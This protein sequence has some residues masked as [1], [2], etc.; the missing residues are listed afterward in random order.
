MKKI[1]IILLIPM[2]C[3][4]L[5]WGIS[6]ARCEIF[7]LMHGQE[8]AELYKENTMLGEQ[9]Y[10]RV[11]DYSETYARVYYVGIKH[12]GANILSFVKKNDQ[13]KY[14]KWESTV[15]SKGGSASDVIWPYWWHFIY[16][17]F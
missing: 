2:M 10:W 17:G 14:D 4:L 3:F 8:F 5:I 11:L 9:E 6:L 16:G 15:W 7:T 12:S 1:L 13:W